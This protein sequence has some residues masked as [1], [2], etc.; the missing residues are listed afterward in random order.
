MKIALIVERLDAGACG[1]GQWTVSLARHLAGN[2]HD[3]HVLTF[4]AVAIPGLDA[5]IHLLRPARG[6]LDQAACVA[7]ALRALAPITVHDIGMSASGDVFQPQ[8]GSRLLSQAR[9]VGTHAPLRRLRAAMSPPSIRWRHHM[10]RLERMQIGRASQVIAVSRLVRDCLARQHAIDPA[11]MQVVYNG[12]DTAAFAPARLAPLRSLARAQLGVG[13]SV[14]FLISAYNLWLKG[15]DTAIRAL[16]QLG[17]DSRLVVAGGVPD[18]GWLRLAAQCGVTD[19]VRWL[20]PVADMLPLFAAADAV[21]H[22]TRWDA[23][24]LSTIEAGAAGLAVVTTAQ[25]GASELVAEGQT[26]FVLADPN[27]PPALRCRMRSLLDPTIRQRMGHAA[28][29]A[30]A[31]MDIGRNLAA[32]ERA[33]TAVVQPG[34][35]RAAG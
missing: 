17:G 24:S 26:G 15:V 6:C 10:A 12:V 8:T 13:Q 2:G 27:D 32:V 29:A 14:V 11:G 9:L 1:A 35:P 18:A 19:R 33:I 7:A 21:V 5:T 31:G 34:R 25:N 30:S 23:C 28:L 3:V 20:G 22:P 4:S 16:A